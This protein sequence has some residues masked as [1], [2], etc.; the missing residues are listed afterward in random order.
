MPEEKILPPNTEVFPLTRREFVA[1]VGGAAATTAV[2]SAVDL[3]MLPEP[4]EA[5]ETPPMDKFHSLVTLQVNGETHRLVIDNRATL[6]EVLRNDLGL[7]GTKVGCSRGECGACTVILDG[8]AVYSCSLL[9]VDAQHSKIETIEGMA[10]GGRLHPL[11]QA[12]LEHDAMQCGFCIPGQLMALK[13][14][15]DHR[16]EMTREELRQAISGNVCRCGCY[17]NIVDAAQQAQ[18]VMKKV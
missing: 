10:V 12:F 3:T 5:A 14:A 15:L 16:S 11:Q 4:L 7:T 8:R 18:R 17:A 9:A 13:A 2:L 6:A 1:T